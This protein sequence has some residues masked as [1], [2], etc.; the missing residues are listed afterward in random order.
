MH[1][2][3]THKPLDSPTFPRHV[4]EKVHFNASNLLSPNWPRW[5]FL[6]LW[7]IKITFSWQLAICNLLIF[8]VVVYCCIA[9]QVGTELLLPLLINGWTTDCIN[10][11]TDCHSGLNSTILSLHVDDLYIIPTC[12]FFFLF[13]SNCIC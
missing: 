3:H 4:A 11:P 1:C 9:L 2:T 5:S 7:K 13:K 12:N 8:L 10:S 6:R